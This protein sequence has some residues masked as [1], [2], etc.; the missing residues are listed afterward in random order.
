MAVFSSFY[1]VLKNRLLVSPALTAALIAPAVIA[2]HIICQRFRL[3]DPG[4]GG[5]V[6]NL[7]LGPMLYMIPSSYEYAPM[8][9]NHGKGDGIID[10]EV[11]TNYTNA[12]LASMISHVKLVDDI[13]VEL[14]TG[15]DGAGGSASWISPYGVRLRLTTMQCDQLSLSELRTKIKVKAQ[16]LPAV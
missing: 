8:T 5:H 16:L 3:G 14:M 2:D 7:L 4:D 1:V 6:K 9:E 10:I 12:N 11:H 13:C 15:A